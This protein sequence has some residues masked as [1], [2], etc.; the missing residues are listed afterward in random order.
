MKYQELLQIAKFLQTQKRLNLIKRLADNALCVNFGDFELIFDMSRGASAIYRADLMIKNYN[1][2]FDI[3]LAK[4]FSN[5]EIIELGTLENNRVLFIKTRALKSYKALNAKIYFEFTG[6]NTNA[7]IV[8]ENECVI[9]ALRHIDKSY[10]V[11]KCGLKLAPLKPFKMDENFEK[12]TNFNEYFNSVFECLNAQKIKATKENKKAILDKKIATLNKMLD[13]LEKENELLSK[14]GTLAQKAQILMA[15]LYKIKDYERDFTLEDFSGKSLE[16][17]LDKSPKMWAN[18]AFKEAKKLRQKATN[19]HLQRNNLN[20]KLDFYK[21]LLMLIN[22][23]NSVFECEILLPKK[24][25][26]EKKDEKNSSIARFYYNDFAILIGKNEKANEFLL[27]NA[28]K[29]DLWFHIKDYPS[30][31]A[32]IVS[33]KQKISENVIQFVAKLCVEFSNLNKG[34]YFVDYTRRNFVSVRQKA[35]VNYTNYRSL[36]VIKE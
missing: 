18:E 32:F 28:K 27:K 26:R 9:E 22:K 24:D 31:H 6:K 23:A 7:I 30:A 16:F 20:E 12:I 10:R 2:P 17:K 34:V 21:K 5:A 29:D 25:K 35:F 8:D 1:A 14:A 36:K 13:S 15:N 33:N 4:Y 19:L 11:V 3:M